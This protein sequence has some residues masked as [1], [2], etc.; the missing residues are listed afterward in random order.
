MKKLIY[1]IILLISA[2]CSKS[3]YIGTGGSGDAMCKFIDIDNRDGQIDVSEKVSLDVKF[4]NQY[5]NYCG[6]AS[7]EMVLDYYG[8]N[9]TQKELAKMI[10]MNVNEGVS[11][12]DIID[13][14]KELGFNKSSI[15]S[16]DLGVLLYSVDK[17]YPVIVRT[18]DS[19]LEK[20]HYMVVVGYDINKELLIVNDPAS[21]TDT[22][23]DS[24]IGSREI[25]F[26]DF[27]YLWNINLLGDQNN[28]YNLMILIK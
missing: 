7:L 1:L 21:F 5:E 4:V 26:E 22:K 6:P 18:Y 23:I 10:D 27:E 8:L 13:L 16:C 15:A 12:S 24:Y 20:A 3:E 28:S 11:P 14:V 17:G 25:S 19:N 9:Y 2:S